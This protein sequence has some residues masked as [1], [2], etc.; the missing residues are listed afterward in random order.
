MTNKIY[1]NLPNYLKCDHLNEF[2]KHKNFYM[3]DLRII[4]HVFFFSGSLAN[5]R[6]FPFYSFTFRLIFRVNLI[7]QFLTSI[8]NAPFPRVTLNKQNSK[9]YC[10]KLYKKCLNR[11]IVIEIIKALYEGY[12][13]KFQNSIFIFS[14]CVIF[15]EI[16]SFFLRLKVG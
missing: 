13:E 15:F 1:K 6:I 5:Q 11:N 10:K 8:K 4:S 14:S 12:K 9:K 2:V 16:H 7:K 3:N